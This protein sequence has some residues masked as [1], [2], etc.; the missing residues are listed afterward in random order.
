[1]NIKHLF[2]YIETTRCSFHIIQDVS[3]KSYTVILV[4]EEEAE[5]EQDSQLSLTSSILCI[6]KQL[7]SLRKPMFYVLTSSVLVM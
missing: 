6:I 1:M 3:N 5:K 4:T 2:L 7:S